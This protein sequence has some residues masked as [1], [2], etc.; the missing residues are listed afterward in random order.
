MRKRLRKKK[1]L[2]EFQ[3]LGFEVRTTLRPGLSETEI[4]AFLDRVIAFVESRGLGYGGGD[5]SAFVSYLGR[6]SVTE[7]DREAF[8]AF[9]AGDAAV[10][11]YELGPLC[12]AWYG[13]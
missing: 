4:D 7:Q 13:W 9:L 2:G 1:R 10:E 6:G 5:T 11:R 8:S 3:E 12:D